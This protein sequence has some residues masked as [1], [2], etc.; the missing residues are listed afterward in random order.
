MG[1]N[2]DIRDYLRP[3]VRWWWL[4]VAAMITAILAAFIYIASQPA[5]YVSRTTILVGSSITDPNPNGTEIY[6]AS[7]LAEMYTDMANRAPMR[8][9]TMDAL[10]MTYLP[11][12][13]VWQ[14]VG[15]PVI[16]VQVLDEDPQRAFAVAQELAKQIVL[17]GPKEE[18]DRQDFIA[19]Q[20][21]KLQTSITKSEADIAQREDELLAIDSAREIAKVQTEIKALQDKMTTLQRNYAELLAT[22]QQGAT[23]TLHMIEPPTVPTTPMSSNLLTNLLVAAV[24]GLAL[25]AG[26]AYILEYLDN[27]YRDAEE[28]RK[29][30]GVT[31]LGS[32][33]A[34]VA[35]EQ[36]LIAFQ[37]KS[38][39]FPLL[40][41]YRRIRT[42]LQFATVDHPLQLLL[43]TST[44]SQDGKSHTAAN[45]SI[46][47]ASTG[48]RVVLL[49]ADLH[50]PSQHRLFNLHNYFGVTTALLRK[51]GDIEQLLQSTNVP[52]LSV[53]TSG[54]LPPNPAELLGSRRMQEI[55]TTLKGLADTVVIDSPPIAVVVDGLL[56]AAQVDGV[57]MVVRAGKTGRDEAKRSLAA[58][59][60]AK[61]HILGAILFATPTSQ[62]D[63]YRLKYGYYNAA[64]AQ[65]TDKFSTI[66]DATPNTAQPIPKM[67][68][69]TEDEVSGGGQSGGEILPAVSDR[70][71]NGATPRPAPPA[72]RRRTGLPWK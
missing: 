5:V 21:T 53:L 56:L 9:A 64:Y 14:S 67:P 11:Y 25:A 35:P 16:E 22:T 19:Q 41:A 4:L 28:M 15:R 34:V 71:L 60:Q 6:L 23:N 52:N 72:V 39:P 17:L 26:G 65:G 42:N 45:L 57:L 49:D 69:T 2:F 61:A 48:K 46:A 27:T 1:E 47:L 13:Q 20:L 31:L 55:L 70:P 63:F 7:Q 32:L 59:R 24:L 68:A 29:T 18:L 10:G 54:P 33:P 12:F 66:G 44:Q 37:H 30:L 36:R 40:E 50:R 43:V 58:L 62:V 3:L 38:V 51:D 8:Q